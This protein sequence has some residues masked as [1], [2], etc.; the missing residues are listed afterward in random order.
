MMGVVVGMLGYY[1]FY[2]NQ[3]SLLF[4]HL[5]NILD[6][7]NANT[8]ILAWLCLFYTFQEQMFVLFLYY[9][10]VLK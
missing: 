10:I 8:R 2:Y 4:K 6:Y 9:I 1:G 5:L 7:Q 3:Y